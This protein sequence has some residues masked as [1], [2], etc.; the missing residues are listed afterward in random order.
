M[1][2]DKQSEKFGQPY[3]APSAITAGS[4]RELTRGPVDPESE[5]SGGFKSQANRQAPRA[6]EQDR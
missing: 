6:E 3:D 5:S 1:N 4:V 2:I